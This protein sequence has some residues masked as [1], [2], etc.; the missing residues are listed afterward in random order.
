MI[1]CGTLHNEN[2]C[3]H[4][5]FYVTPMEK[6]STPAT[7]K[8]R[9]LSKLIGITN[10]VPGQTCGMIHVNTIPYRWR[11]MWKRTYLKWPSCVQSLVGSWHVGSL[12]ASPCLPSRGS[13]TASLPGKM[14]RLQGYYFP[15]LGPSSNFSGANPLLNFG[16]VFHP[17]LQL[18]GMI[19]ANLWWF[20]MIRGFQ[21]E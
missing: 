10:K 20:E 14:M 3:S 18:L 5:V 12:Q 7:K 2:P 1:H 17:S 4:G 9:N 11:N 21:A 8:M 15:E 19:F 6:N 16:R 13:L